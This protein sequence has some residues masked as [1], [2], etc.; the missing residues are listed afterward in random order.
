MK[1]LS[2]TV[3]ACSYFFMG[4]GL[5]TYTPFRVNRGLYSLEKG[6]R[7]SREEKGHWLKA[8]G[9]EMPHLHVEE[10]RR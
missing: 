7:I 6:V 5:N 1:Q 3:L 4:V 9:S 8:T 2:K 10:F